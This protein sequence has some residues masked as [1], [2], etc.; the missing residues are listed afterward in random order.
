VNIL[1]KIVSRR[2]RFP[3]ASP[4]DPEPAD[5]S[6]LAPRDSK[7]LEGLR[8]LVRSF[9]ASGGTYH[10]LDFGEGLV[11]EGDYDLRRYLRFYA[12]PPRLDGM[13]VL[14]VGTASGFF[15]LEC[16]RRG[17]RVTA[18]DLYERPLLADLAGLVP[19]ADV[20]YIRKSVYDLDADFGRFDLVICGSL[21]PHVSDQFGAVQKLRTV[22]GGRLVVSTACPPDSPHNERPVCEFIGCKA[23]DG[24]YWAWWTV[25]WLALR[26][27]L[28]AAGFAR[29][30]N[31]CHF[32]LTSE[33]GR[34]QFSTP[35]VVMTGWV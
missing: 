29:V 10:R 33:E 31:I 4:P 14:D 12:L 11:I 5:F 9:N 34:I 27:M 20:R 28:L 32:T 13:S 22:C 19:G 23:A 8:E 24:D 1:S 15:A 21:L 17:A 16:A 35:H 18:I 2:H 3:F 25:G 26:Q 7:R 30:E 6:A